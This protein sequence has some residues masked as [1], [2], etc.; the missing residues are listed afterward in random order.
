MQCTCGFPGLLVHLLIGFW[1][2]SIKC[3][4]HDAQQYHIHKPGTLGNTTL[5]TY[6]IHVPVSKTFSQSCIV[7]LLITLWQLSMYWQV[8]VHNLLAHAGC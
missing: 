6:S 7:H 1:S 2:H 8:C 5:A 3:E 4:T